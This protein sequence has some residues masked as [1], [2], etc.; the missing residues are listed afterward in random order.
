M[1]IKKIASVSIW[2]IVMLLGLWRRPIV[3]GIYP[4]PKHRGI[5]VRRHGERDYMRD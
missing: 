3:A 2:N 1:Q 4:L 5:G